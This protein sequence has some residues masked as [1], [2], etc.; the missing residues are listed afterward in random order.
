MLKI[1][2]PIAL[3]AAL[4]VPAIATT[5]SEQLGLK[6]DSQNAPVQAIVIDSAEMP[7]AD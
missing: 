4:S 2:A 1:L 6:L 7:T 3:S 5:L